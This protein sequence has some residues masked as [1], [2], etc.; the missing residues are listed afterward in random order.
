MEGKHRTCD[1][2]DRRSRQTGDEL[3]VG[4]IVA[5]CAAM[6]EAEVMVEADRGDAFMD[7]VYIGQE[8]RGD[9]KEHFLRFLVHFTT[10]GSPVL[11][12]LCSRTHDFTAYLWHK[13]ALYHLHQH[14][15]GKVPRTMD[16]AS[17]FTSS[18]SCFV[19]SSPLARG[20]TC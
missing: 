4:F 17:V 12:E 3:P 18:A 6:R 1:P 5:L 13:H 16:F 9:A 7:I 11:Y 14:R 10:G 19:A 15:G 2:H 20:I 8:L